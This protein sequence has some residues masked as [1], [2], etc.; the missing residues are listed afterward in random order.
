[1]KLVR[2]HINEFQQGQNPYD[3][4]GVGS[5]R[6]FYNEEEIQLTSDV[7]LINVYG[8]RFKY[9]NGSI[10]K[11]YDDPHYHN[12][13]KPYFYDHDSGIMYDVAELLKYKNN[14]KRI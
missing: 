6:P 2:E 3:T 1:M 10:F 5:N 8:R 14:W 9:L 11:Y 7:I 4:M 13:M 12:K